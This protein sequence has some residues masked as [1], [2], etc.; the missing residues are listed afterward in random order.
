MFYSI[1]PGLHVASVIP[2]SPPGQAFNHLPSE[3]YSQYLPWTPFIVIHRDVRLNIY[4]LFIRPYDRGSRPTVYEKGYFDHS[5]D[6]GGP[7]YLEG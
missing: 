2:S 4:I 7:Q 3:M 6:G 1:P 5:K